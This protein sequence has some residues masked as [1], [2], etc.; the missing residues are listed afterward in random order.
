MPRQGNQF[1]M[2][3]LK[4]TSRQPWLQESLQFDPDYLARKYDRQRYQARR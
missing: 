4:N 3:V 2:C 1:A